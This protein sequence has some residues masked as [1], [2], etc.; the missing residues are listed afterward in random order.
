MTFLCAFF[1]R[2][3]L[4]EAHVSDRIQGILLDIEGTT[5]SVHFVFEVM[6]PFVR[7]ELS[8]YLQNNW[9]QPPL[10]EALTLIAKDAGLASFPNWCE[11]N[12][13]QTQLAQQQL[14]I[15]EI[16]RL[17]DADI[18]ATGLKHLQGLI[19]EAGFASGE[20]RA[21]V[22]DDVLPALQTW[23]TDGKDIRIYSSGSIYAQHL[24]FGHSI[25]GNLLSYFSGH[26]DTTIGS[27]KEA[28]SYTR[29]AEQWG[30]ASNAILFVSDILAELNA[31]Q[32]AGLQ[33]ALA[34]RP[35]NSAITESH[36]H[37]PIHSFSD[38]SL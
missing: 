7:R 2:F 15:Q 23:K 4:V 12:A 6:F 8:S 24:F 11:I 20:L 19:W 33:T 25:A 9:N 14:V 27:K 1:I 13:A 35:G 31:A 3:H 17:M 30:L 22:F 32:A 5:S 37:R 21:Q 34:I 10:Q 18:K 28:A 16:T 38:I 36:T 29:I 26:Y